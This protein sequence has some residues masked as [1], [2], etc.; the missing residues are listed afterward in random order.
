MYRKTL[1]LVGFSMFVINITLLFMVLLPNIAPFPGVVNYDNIIFFLFP[2]LLYLAVKIIKT[3]RVNA[4]LYLLFIMT[5][6]AALLIKPMTALAL[7]VPI[8]AYVVHDSWKKYH[9][10]FFKLLKKSFNKSNK[11]VKIL[12]PVFIVVGV[13]L[14]IERPITNFIVYHKTS[15]SCEMILS[16]KRCMKNYTYKRG[17]DFKAT[18]PAVWESLDPFE[19]FS[20]YWFN[21]MVKTN[22]RMPGQSSLPIINFLYFAMAIL[23]SAFILIN[24]KSLIRDKYLRMIIGG[25]AFFVAALM[26]ENYRAYI[27]LG[28]PVAM[29]GRYL[30]PYLPIFGV[31][32]VTSFAQLFKKSTRKWIVVIAIP[33]ILLL[34]FQGGGVLTTTLTQ[35]TYWTRHSSSK[36]LN[37]NVKNTITPLIKESPLFN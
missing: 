29:S 15:P 23:G 24:L 28:Q 1:K 25:F 16:K 33:T 26:Y 32:A 3:P 27:S 31:L 6:I 10:D 30:L 12:L 22:I 14:L 17:V 20:K 19:Y 4:V 18:K 37:E 9:S 21:S 11:L 35:D 34:M 5:I 2:T 7:S 8:L 36:N 13:G